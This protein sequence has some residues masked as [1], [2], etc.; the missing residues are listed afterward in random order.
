MTTV[1]LGLL[2]GGAIG[3]LARPAAATATSSTSSTWAS[4]TLRFYTYNVADAAISTAIVLLIAMAL[5]PR[6]A[7]WGADD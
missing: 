6:I 2:L 7:E 1:A 4:A 3:N 5:V